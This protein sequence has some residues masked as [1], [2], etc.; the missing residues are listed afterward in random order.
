LLQRPSAG[1]VTQSMRCSTG[2]SSLERSHSL[3]GP[4]LLAVGQQ[5]HGT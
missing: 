2:R 5:F 3:L 1:F 4:R